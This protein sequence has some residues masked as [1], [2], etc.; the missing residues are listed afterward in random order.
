M[1]VFVF[2]AVLLCGGFQSPSAFA[3]GDVGHRVICQIAYEELKPEIKARVD[4]LVAI[5]PK[6]RTFADACTA[7]D[8]PH[9]RSPE[10]YVDLP[11]SAKG[12]E[13]AHPCPVADRCVISAILNDTRDLAFS[14]DVSDQLRLLKSLGHWV[15]D[16]H[17]PL[18]VSLSSEPSRQVDSSD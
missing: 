12:I 17:Q 10:H 3:W 6:F 16:V 15:G 18:H 8:H 14:L 1:R 4:A 2:L 9:I 5:D 7:P 13:V 11:R